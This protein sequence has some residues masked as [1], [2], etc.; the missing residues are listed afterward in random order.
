MHSKCNCLDK[1]VTKPEVL[2]LPASAG[3]KAKRFIPAIPSLPNGLKDLQTTSSTVITLPDAQ[4]QVGSLLNSCSCKNPRKCKC[5]KLKTPS[6]DSALAALAKAAAIQ[7]V[8]SRCCSPS[9]PPPPSKRPKHQHQHPPASIE[10][11][12]LLISESPLPETPGPIPDFGI[13]PPLSEITSLAGSGCTCGIE[14]CC[15]GCAEHRGAENVD[16]TYRPCAHGCG[17]CVDNTHGIALPGHGSNSTSIIDRFFARAAA[18]PAPPANR[19]MGVG[20]QLDPMNVIVY[21]EAAIKTKEHGVPF[22]L[23]TVPKLECCGGKCGCP[24]G[25]CGCGK[26]CDGC[27][28]DHL[29]EKEKG[30]H[31]LSQSKS[32]P[33]LQAHAAPRQHQLKHLQLSEVAAVGRL[34]RNNISITVHQKA[35]GLHE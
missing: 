12:P 34:A 28:A 27:C 9:S 35:Y 26:N 30:R 22:G 2:P 10:L 31:L 18:L 19:K 20:D 13:M 8:P 21:P 23:I 32:K 16:T 5:R 24:G 33:K 15:P 6:G 14:C 1:D 17:T 7:E 29:A 3:T 25:K 11:P 4:K